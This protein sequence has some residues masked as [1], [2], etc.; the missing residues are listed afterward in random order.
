MEGRGVQKTRKGGLLAGLS[1]PCGLCG[2]G[3]PAWLGIFKSR[4]DKAVS[5]FL[6]G[7][8]SGGRIQG[9][10]SADTGEH[11]KTGVR[12]FPA[13]ADSNGGRLGSAGCKHSLSAGTPDSGLLHWLPGGRPSDSVPEGGAVQEVSGFPGRIYAGDLCAAFPFCHR[14]ESGQ[15]LLSL[16]LGG[17]GIRLC[18]LCGDESYYGG[19]HCGYQEIL[20]A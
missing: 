2:S 1:G 20:A 16:H 7:R 5:A 6:P 19:D 17:A 10:D 3:D 18:L 4:P 12:G 11:E 13:G 15:D 9:M 8:L 14:A